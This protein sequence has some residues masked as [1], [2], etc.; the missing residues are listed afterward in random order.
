MK[1]RIVFAYA[2]E[3]I[4]KFSYEIR[5]KYYSERNIDVVSYN[6]IHIKF[7]M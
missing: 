1:M 6:E 3:R 4:T 7:E 2:L 5:R